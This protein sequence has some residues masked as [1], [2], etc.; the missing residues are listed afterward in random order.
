MIKKDGSNKA[1]PD[2]ARGNVPSKGR[3][4]LTGRD[5]NAGH[6]TELIVDHPTGQTVLSAGLQ[7][8]Q[9]ATA[10]KDRGHQGKDQRDKVRRTGRTGQNGETARKRD[11]PIDQN[12]DH[13]I[14]VIA[15]L[16]IGL[17]VDHPTAH[18]AI[19]LKDKARQ[20][21]GL[22]DKDH[23]TDKIV[24]NVDHRIGR[25]ALNADHQTG[26][27]HQGVTDPADKVAIDK[28]LPA[29]GQMDKVATARDHPATA[30]MDQG[31]RVT[32]KDPI[33]NLQGHQQMMDL[34]PWIKTYSTLFYTKPR[35]QH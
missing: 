12:V 13:P 5:Q 3:V 21:K 11:L 22:P 15:D 28:A 24:R 35:L 26:R 32:T 2:P 18:R 14:E 4:E 19:V 7:T 30:R 27:D 33:P 10:L 20:G 9:V 23:R 34:H 25:T 8:D 1:L 17:N 16:P 6:Q 31:R 29:I